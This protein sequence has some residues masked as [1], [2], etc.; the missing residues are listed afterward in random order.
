MSRPVAFMI[1]VV[2]ATSIGCGDEK[3]VQPK[4]A[5]PVPK[6]I[7]FSATTGGGPAGLQPGPTPVLKPTRSTP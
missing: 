2:L 1:T 6:S 5:A 3:T 4:H 7:P